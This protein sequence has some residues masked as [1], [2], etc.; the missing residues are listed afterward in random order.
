[1]GSGSRFFGSPGIAPLGVGMPTDNDGNIENI[2]ANHDRA[3]GKVQLSVDEKTHCKAHSYYEKANV[4]DKSL[5]GD[6]KFPNQSHRAGDDGGDEASSTYQLANSHTTAVGAH[7]SKGT[8]DVGRAISEGQEGHTSQALAQSKK[9]RDGAQVDAEKVTRSNANG[10]KEQAKPEDQDDKCQ[11]LH[12]AEA[13]VVECQILDEAGFFVATVM[14]DKGALIGC[15]V[16]QAT[17]LVRQ[18]GQAALMMA[19]SRGRRYKG[20]C[21]C[22]RRRGCEM[23]FDYK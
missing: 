13:A 2:E 21:R 18:G 4:S 16:D 9:G 10:G 22:R 1:M 3:L 17:V 5:P 11:G 12:V 19:I 15:A 20:R 7:G 6:S 23:F 8:E 14:L